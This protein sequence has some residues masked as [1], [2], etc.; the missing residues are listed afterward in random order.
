[1]KKSLVLLFVLTAF[2]SCKNETKTEAEKEAITKDASG[3]T[4]KQ[5]D[6]LVLLRG[7][8]VYYADAAV[9]QTPNNAMYGVILNKKMH[10]LN[11][12]A[13]PFKKE[14]TDYVFVELRGKLIPK[15]ENEEGWDYRIDIKEILKVTASKADGVIKLGSK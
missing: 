5:N 15:P 1:M 4:L 6:G 2:I 12:L 8:F 7:E 3:K 10:E 11:D 14:A 9:L 13:K